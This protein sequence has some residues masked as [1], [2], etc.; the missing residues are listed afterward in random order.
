[1][2]GL[3]LLCGFL[4]GGCG[5]GENSEPLRPPSF[6]EVKKFD[7]YPVYYSGSKV[8]GLPL[9]GISEGRAGRWVY[10][11]LS[12]GDCDPP[13]GFFAEG[14]CSLPLSVQN[15]STCYRWASQLHQNLDLSDFR[16]AKAIGGAGGSQQEI[17]TGRTTVVIFAH[18]QSVANSAARQLRA[19]GQP[20]PAP[21]PPPVP[22]SLR[23]KLPCQGKPG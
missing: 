1:M 13:S 9:T 2:V 16:G 17:L 15:W 8:A 19:V 21:L 22:G 14:G 6:S 5:E 7:S 18:E 20:R 11:N 10:W 3:G 4:F 23:G 12:Y